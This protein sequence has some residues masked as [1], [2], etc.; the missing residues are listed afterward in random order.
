MPTFFSYFEKF[1]NLEHYWPA[2]SAVLLLCNKTLGGKED[3]FVT[4]HGFAKATST[5]T[6][7]FLKKYNLIWMPDKMATLFPWK[8]LDTIMGGKR[9]LLNK[10]TRW[11]NLMVLVNNPSRSMGF[12]L[13]ILIKFLTLTHSSHKKYFKK[14]T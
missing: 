11:S 3:Y 6:C 5:S 7:F 10:L 4:H 12:F 2:L 8:S 9:C 13:Y 14:N 1:D